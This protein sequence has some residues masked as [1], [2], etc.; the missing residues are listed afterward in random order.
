MTRAPQNFGFVFAPPTR[1]F[2][3]QVNAILSLVSIPIWLCLAPFK[4]PG[5]PQRENPDTLVP[6][7]R[8]SCL[9][10]SHPSSPRTRHPPASAIHH[11]A[12]GIRHPPS[13]IRQLAS[14]IRHLPFATISGGTLWTRVTQFPGLPV[15]FR[16][17]LGRPIQGRPSL[18]A[19]RLPASPY[20]ADWSPR[21]KGHTRRAARPLGG[22][23]G[24]SP[25]ANYQGPSAL[26]RHTDFT[27]RS[28]K[29]CEGLRNL[30]SS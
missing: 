7:A 20:Q 3:I 13:A 8:C 2:L 9:L 30:V 4:V 10:R 11:L 16:A 25:T 29:S 24:L 23:A 1:S 27:T 15:P 12:S 17:G 21:V 14:G 28:T 26:S 19:C 22:R 5:A 6:S 18:S